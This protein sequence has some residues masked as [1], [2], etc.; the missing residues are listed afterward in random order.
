MANK[1]KVTS[2][3]NHMSPEE[4]MNTGDIHNLIAGNTVKKLKIYKAADEDDKI[5]A[6]GTLKF[7]V[8]SKICEIANAV[9]KSLTVG[10]EYVLI[11]IGENAKNANKPTNRGKGKD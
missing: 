3:K 11:K 4:W 10:I 8:F 2:S 5:A 9:K 7:D 6:A 1:N